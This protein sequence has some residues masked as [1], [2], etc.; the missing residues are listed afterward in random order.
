MS[1]QRTFFVLPLICLLFFAAGA[2]RAQAGGTVGQNDPSGTIINTTYSSTLGVTFSDPV[3]PN[4][5]VK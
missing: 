3:S 4:S 1:N 2:R 5:N